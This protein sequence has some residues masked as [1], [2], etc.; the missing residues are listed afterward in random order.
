MDTRFEHRIA[1]DPALVE[2]TLLSAD[3]ASALAQRCP[4]LAEARVLDLVARG[5][6]VERV[7]R[8]RARAG[9]LGGPFGLLPALAWTERVWWSRRAH[10]GRFEV[11]P[12]LPSALSQ[13]VC[14]EGSYALLPDGDG[15]TLR[16]VDVALTIRAPWVAGAAEARIAGMLR[17]LFDAEAALLERGDG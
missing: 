16:R 8:L 13:R 15:A 6:A 2:A 17:A 5:D 4:V 12:E 9:A 3:F 10:E 7:T 14:C 1:R 11:T